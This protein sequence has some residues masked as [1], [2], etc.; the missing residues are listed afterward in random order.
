MFEF[1]LDIYFDAVNLGNPE[2]E[3]EGK[4]MGRV[5]VA[6]FNQDDDDIDVDVV[7]EK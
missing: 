5:T 6:E 2:D 1:K 7:C 3:N 4:A